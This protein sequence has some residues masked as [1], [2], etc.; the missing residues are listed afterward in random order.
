MLEA[1]QQN[2]IA[3]FWTRLGALVID[4]LLLGLFGLVLGH[5]FS[6]QFAQMGSWGRLVGF[7][8]GLIYFGVMNSALLGGQTVGK[9]LLRIRVVDD[10]NNTIPLFRSMLRYI[11]FILPLTLNGVYFTDK[12]MPHF[13]DK[14][15][16]HFTDKVMP[17]FT[18]KVMP[19][20]GNYPLSFFMLGGMFAIIYL[21]LYNRATRQSLHDLMVGTFVVNAYSVKQE[22]SKVW[23]VHLIVV[24]IAFIAAIIPTAYFPKLISDV[25]KLVSDA[26]YTGM[27]AAQSALL[28]EPRIK[29]ASVK[30]SYQTIISENKEDQ[31]ATYVIA[32]AWLTSNNVADDELAQYVANII[33]Q[34]YPEAKQTD[35]I[36]I[37]LAY[38]YDIGIAS[39]WNSY[40]L[41]FDPKTL[42]N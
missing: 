10:K 4:G 24:A 8:I 7:G 35:A 3:G 25:S 1:T 15:M 17:H 28:N 29:S 2:W 33:V 23:K 5:F 42:G 26:S 31:Q 11:V 14:E 9:K 32:K 36:K 19:Y 20:I 27:S 13:T 34:H 30:T 6:D 40:T 18:D 41:S 39:K 22:T 38:G 12:E 16:P 21:Y 37:T